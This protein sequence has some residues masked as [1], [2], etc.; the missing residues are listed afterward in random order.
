MFGQFGPLYATT[1]EAKYAC[2]PIVSMTGYQFGK[3]GGGNYDRQYNDL[4]IAI[5]TPLS[6]QYKYESEVQY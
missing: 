5:P 2:N 4:S 6:A 1:F 3:G